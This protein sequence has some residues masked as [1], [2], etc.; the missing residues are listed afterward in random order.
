MQGDIELVINRFSEIEKR[1]VDALKARE[2]MV[3]LNKFY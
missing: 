1:L 3:T 2:K